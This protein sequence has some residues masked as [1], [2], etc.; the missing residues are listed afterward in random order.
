MTGPQPP[1]DGSDFAIGDRVRIRLRPRVGGDRFAGRIGTIVR[2]HFAGFY[3]R[4][5]MSPRERVQKTELVETQ[6]LAPVT[7]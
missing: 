3:V 1:S 2:T 7:D 4:L 6:Y 5:D